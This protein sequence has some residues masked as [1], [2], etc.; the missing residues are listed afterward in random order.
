M[1][2]LKVYSYITGERAALVG[3]E[4]I[5]SAVFRQGLFQG[6]DAKIRL[7][8]VGKTPGRHVAAVPVHGGDHVQKAFSH[9]NISNIN[10][11]D[12]IASGD[13]QAAQQVGTAFVFGVRDAFLGFWRTAMSPISLMS[14][15]M[16]FLPA[17]H[18]N[19]TRSRL[20]WRT[21]RN[22]R[23]VNAR[24]ISRIRARFMAGSPV[25]S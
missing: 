13:A 8:S 12:L 3:V 23:S 10:T 2:P 25:R 14:R 22:G 18:P 17:L 5:R 20:L 19:D 1:A 16:R 15:R 6:R 9:G 7:H 21:P 24:S 4:D 11:P